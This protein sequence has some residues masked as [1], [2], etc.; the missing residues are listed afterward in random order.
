M[1][2]LSAGA[3]SRGADGRFTARLNTFRLVALMRRLPVRSRQAVDDTSNSIRDMA[4]QLAPRDTGSLAA[5][6]YVS[7][8]ETSDYSQ[9]AAAARGLNHNAVIEQEVRPEFVLSLFG[10]TSNAF[11]ALVASAVG[12]AVFQEHGTRFQSAQPFLTPAIE[13]H[14][15]PFVQA[16]S[17]VADT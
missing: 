14:R 10:S 1:P 11:V 13:A 9:C 17:H 2:T 7:N 8:G 16:M 12:H 15:D 4:R 5:S 6:L 3:Q